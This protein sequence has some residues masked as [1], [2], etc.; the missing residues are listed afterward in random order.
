MPNEPPR[1]ADAVFSFGSRQSATAWR[2]HAR[3]AAR[4][5]S[6]PASAAPAPGGSRSARRRLRSAVSRISSACASSCSGKLRSSARHS[7]SATAAPSRL[8]GSGCVWNANRRR[9][10]DETFTATDWPLPSP[11]PALPRVGAFRPPRKSPEGTERTLHFRHSAASEAH[12]SRRRAAAPPETFSLVPP[13]NASPSVSASRRAGSPARPS[14]TASSSAT[15]SAASRAWFLVNHRT[16]CVAS[17]E[18]S[19][20]HTGSWSMAS[21]ST[22]GNNRRYILWNGVAS[23]AWSPPS[24]ANARALRPTISSVAACRNSAAATFA[25]RSV[26]DSAQCAARGSIWSSQMVTRA[27][28]PTSTSS[29]TRRSKSQSVVDDDDE[30]EEEDDTNEPDARRSSSST[31]SCAAPPTAPSTRATRASMSCSGSAERSAAR[32]VSTARRAERYASPAFR[33][34]DASPASNAPTSPPASVFSEALRRSTYARSERTIDGSRARISSWSRRR[35]VVSRRVVSRASE[36]AVSADRVPVQRSRTS[37]AARA[38]GGW[39]APTA[40][41]SRSAGASSRAASR[42]AGA[43]RSSCSAA[44]RSSS[45]RRSAPASTSSRNARHVSLAAD[46]S[47]ADSSSSLRVSSSRKL[48]SKTPASSAATSATRAIL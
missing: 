6:A 21:S 33:R 10:S 24:G 12:R 4:A 38:S 41:A 45:E 3:V 30:K 27:F 13:V 43:A 18:K 42:P 19:C 23:R 20:L 32:A 9:S 35:R 28:S 31:S 36:D 22:T 11:L 15:V 25:A 29:E 34:F 47:E 39:C 26:E 40:S 48:S 37:S 8:A 44:A 46:R 1:E 5:R 14:T 17:A 2:A 16:S 7:L